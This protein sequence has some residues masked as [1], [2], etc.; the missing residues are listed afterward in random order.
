MEYDTHRAFFWRVEASFEES[1]RKQVRVR[2]L[3][4]RNPK[5]EVRNVRAS[6]IHS[7]LGELQ[8]L[9]SY[10]VDGTGGFMKLGGTYAKAEISEVL[11]LPSKVGLEVVLHQEFLYPEK[12]AYPADIQAWVQDSNT[13]FHDIL[14]SADL[15]APEGQ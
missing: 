7:I 6:H 4:S 12:S 9:T 1:E 5:S 2:T 3:I 14:R 15:V 13:K 10:G 8:R 11:N